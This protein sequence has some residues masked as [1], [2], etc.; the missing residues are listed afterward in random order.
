MYEDRIPHRDAVLFFLLTTGRV[1]RVALSYRTSRTAQPQPALQP[2][3]QPASSLQSLQLSLS[4]PPSQL[5]LQPSLSDLTPSSV[6]P[7]QLPPQAPPASVGCPLHR[8]RSRHE[9]PMTDV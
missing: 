7:P 8:H 3:L 5:P 4:S 2:A 6:L 1:G 9:V